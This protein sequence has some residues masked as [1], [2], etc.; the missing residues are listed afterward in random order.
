VCCISDHL[1]ALAAGDRM[2]MEGSMQCG[3]E[4]SPGYQK[5]Y[6]A[7]QIRKRAENDA[8]LLQKEAEELSIISSQHSS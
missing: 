3:E 6:R 7:Y 8:L 4:T 2:W 1:K 5:C